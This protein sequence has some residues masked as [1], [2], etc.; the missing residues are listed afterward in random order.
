MHPH[1]AYLIAQRLAEMRAATER[2]GLL[3]TE[4]VLLADGTRFE[5]PADRA[6]GPRPAPFATRPWLRSRAR[7]SSGAR[8]RVMGSCGRRS[9]G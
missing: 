2:S 7:V 1:L 8:L 6:P 5:D 3:D 4:P 9:G